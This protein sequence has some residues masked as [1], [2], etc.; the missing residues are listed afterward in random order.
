MRS[1]GEHGVPFISRLKSRVFSARYKKISA[2][3]DK[4]TFD[5]W[6]W[7]EW[8]SLNYAFKHARIRFRNGFK[9]TAPPIDG[10]IDVAA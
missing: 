7:I 9:N 8:F 1:T 5:E 6:W 3:N 4:N 10:I 2:E